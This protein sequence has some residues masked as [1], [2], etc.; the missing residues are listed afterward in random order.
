MRSCYNALTHRAFNP[1][2]G[3]RR[4]NPAFTTRAICQRQMVYGLLNGWQNCAPKVAHSIVS[5]N[6]RTYR[7]LALLLYR[8]LDVDDCRKSG[9]AV[10]LT[11]WTIALRVPWQQCCG[12]DM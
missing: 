2:T 3:F 6:Q 8:W 10:L 12:A 11:V 7:L 5:G 1:A 9:A 4:L